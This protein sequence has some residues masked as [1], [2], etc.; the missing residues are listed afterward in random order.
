MFNDIYL[1]MVRDGLGFS[2]VNMR[3]NVACN[4]CNLVDALFLANV[5]TFLTA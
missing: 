3:T 1:S 2:F 5:P 4:F